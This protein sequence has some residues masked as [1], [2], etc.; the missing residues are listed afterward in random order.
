MLV[1]HMVIMIII[2]LRVRLRLLLLLFELLVLGDRL[3]RLV[4][5]ML[6]VLRGFCKY[7]SKVCPLICYMMRYGNE[8][9]YQ[10]TGI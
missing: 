6:S 3:V 7:S 5:V 1:V 2:V 9:I 4:L 10:F 8:M